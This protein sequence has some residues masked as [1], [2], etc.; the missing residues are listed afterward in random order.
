LKGIVVALVDEKKAMLKDV[1]ISRSDESDYYSITLTKD[2]IKKL[3][4][5]NFF[6]GL[7][8]CL[9]TNHFL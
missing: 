6:I 5:I 4:G 3:K 1:P 8:K 9:Q 7:L 2:Q